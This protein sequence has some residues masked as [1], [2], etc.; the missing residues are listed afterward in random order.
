M[1]NKIQQRII[2]VLLFVIVTTLDAQTPSTKKQ[3]QDDSIPNLFTQDK[4]HTVYLNFYPTIRGIT[5]GSV[6]LGMGYDY[7][8]GRSFAVGGY[9]QFYT[10]FNNISYDAIIGGKYYPLKTKYGSLYIN[11]GL[12]IRRDQ[13]D[14]ENFHGLIVPLYLGWKYAFKNGLVLDPAFGMRYNAPSFSGADEN[15]SFMTAVRISIG[16]TF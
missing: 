7:N 1:K 8:I 14:E 15:Y 13:R 11:T 16:W 12:G 6:G 9:Y 3:E 5:I 10:N 2:L 4:K